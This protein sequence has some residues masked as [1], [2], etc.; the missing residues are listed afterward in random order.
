MLRL[1]HRDREV[2]AFDEPDPFDE[3]ED[4]GEEYVDGQGEDDAPRGSWWSRI[5]GPRATEPDL[6]HGWTNG[7][8]LTSM[9]ASG[10]LLLMCGSGVAALGLEVL[11]DPAPAPIT[12]PAVTNPA[13]AQDAAEFAEAFVGRFLSTPR[14]QEKQVTD[15]LAAGGTSSLSLPEQPAPIG[16][17]SA[18]GAR[19][20]TDG[21]WISTVA[22]DEP[23]HDDVPPVHR[24]WQV[25]VLADGHGHLAAAALPSMISAPGTGD[26][27]LGDST[28]VS[29]TA[30]RQTVTAFMAAYLAGQGEVA[31]LT[32]PGASITAVLPVPFASTEVQAIRAAAAPPDKPAQGDVV[33]LQVSVTATAADGSKRQLEYSLDLRYRD[34]WEVSAVNSTFPISEGTAS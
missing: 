26:L 5:R 23:A 12:A 2:D 30:V 15:M 24:Y 22:V 9:A 21:Q 10:A 6:A 8:R 31:P 32:A 4:A 25:V 20:T 33:P 14:G 13:D 34:R 27:A 1:R 11:R 29:D 16:A 17:I 3:A 28:T 19:K 18:A 7:Q